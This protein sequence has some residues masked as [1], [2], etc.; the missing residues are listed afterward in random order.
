[1]KQVFL[2]GPSGV[3]IEEV[4]APSPGP[5]EVL[6]RVSYS[7]ISTGTEGAGVKSAARTSRKP[8]ERVLDDPALVLKA[9]KKLV[10]DG[11]QATA[12]AVDGGARDLAPLGYS[13]S[14]VVTEVGEKV[15]GLSVGD[16]VACAGGGYAVHAEYVVVPT[17]LV[18]PVPDGV[19][20]R[21]AAFVTLGA[22]AMQGV[23]RAEVTLGDRVGVVGL[24]LLGQ[25][26]SQIATAAGGRVLGIDLDGSRVALALAT[27]AKAGCDSAERDPVSAAAEIS[28]GVGLDAAIIFAGAP[29]SEIVNQAFEMTRER[30]R[31]VVVGAVGMDLER[32]T[33]YNREQDFLISRSYGPGRYD[34]T[35]EEDGVDYP[36][37][38]VRWTENRNMSAFLELVADGKVSLDALVMG[39]FDIDAA[40]EA[41]ASA[42]SAK[43]PAVAALLRYY[44]DEAV[45]AMR[46]S[47]VTQVSEV[48]PT[49]GEVHF[50]LIGAGSFA[51][52]VHIPN[53]ARIDGA[54]L[55]A[56]VGRRGP[57]A[58]TAAKRAGA[59]YATTDVD[60]M[61]HDPHID[62]VLITTR[63]DT[64]AP[65]TMAAANAG[66]HAF[67]EKPLAMTEAECMAIQQAV[68][69]S[70][71]LVTVGFNRRYSPHTL[72]AKKLLAARRGPKM[73]NYRINA[74]FKELGHWVFDPVE[75]GGRILGEACH[76]F[77][78]L[79][80]F[81]ECEPI[82]VF[83]AALG[84]LG[85]EYDPLDNLAVTLEF[86]DGSVGVVQYAGNGDVGFPKE[87]VEIFC[88]K[89][90]IAIEDF[91][92]T[93]AVGFPGGGDLVTKQID[94]GHAACLE[95]F[96]RAVQGKATLGMG[97]SD[98]IRGTLVALE[99]I[100]S[101]RTGAAR[102][103]DMSPYLA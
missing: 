24:G 15:R 102:T 59:A 40:E 57:A 4:P 66:K 5:G 51:K 27:G 41:Y 103:I 87:R 67:V 7:L 82:R 32:K 88:D 21:D 64:H 98:G 91:R 100:E 8:L 76:F 79:A 26:G 80:H 83:S 55:R 6:V 25:L 17:N 45:P 62:A 30:G 78:L 86:E 38:Y 97:L 11:V 35:Y 58:T 2:G 44:E 73:M 46:P 95:E 50:G 16:R 37:A 84:K 28:D 20:M 1:M 75:G 13:V 93:I 71:V 48:K 101:A 22:I 94:K 47:R 18:V 9:A 43:G 23:R 53:L 39:V 19:S 14:G 81:A 99:A 49:A 61:L 52:A 10:S 36:I 54:S 85:P 56:V 89:T 96:V 69:E 77:D 70:G 63:H 12:K 60:E 33:F 31:V 74:G 34:P 65:L 29:G 42:L 3:R 72:H 92:Q 68:R 90:V